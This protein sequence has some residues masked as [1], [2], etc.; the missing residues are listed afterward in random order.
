MNAR[1]LAIALVVLAAV[2]SAVL[3]GLAGLTSRPEDA[4]P[5]EH[6]EA[7]ARL[8]ARALDRDL[9]ATARGVELGA[10]LFDLPSLPAAETTGVLR[11]LYKQ[12][13]DLTAVVL[14]DGQDQAVVEPVF[15]R[16]EQVASR[17]DEAGH[18]PLSAEG[19]VRCLHNLPVQVAREKGFA[20]SDAYVDPHTNAVLVAGA[21]AVSAGPD[22]PAW[23]LGF[24]RNLRR[25]QKVVTAGLGGSEQTLWVVDGGGRLLAHPDGRRALAREPWAEHPLVAA[26][27]QGQRALQRTWQGADG[28]TMF[29]ALQRLD[30]ADWAVGLELAGPAASPGLP[31][32]WRWAAWFAAVLALAAVG[33]LG[34]RNLQRKLD[35][36]EAL[37]QEAERQQVELGRVQASLLESRKLNAI[38]DLG[39]GVAHEFNN[40]LGGILGLTQLLLRKKKDGDPDVEFLRRIETEA[41]RCKAI[42]DNLLRFSEQAGSNHRE[43]LRIERVMDKAVDLVLSKLDRQ[44]IRIVRDY[45]AELPRVFGS[46]GDLQRAYLNLLLNAETAMPEGGELRLS[47]ATDGDWIVTR[48]ADTGRGIPPENLERVFEPF[49]TTKDNWKGAGLGLWVVY[50]TV[51]EHG[52]SVA[53]E[54]QLGRGTVVTFRLPREGREQP[55]PGVQAA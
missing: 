4:R 18:L 30:T 20:M 15:L 17:G 38:G 42:T 45:A 28:R 33:L 22:Q 41:K 54:S 29:G 16:V 39:A 19:L 52:G 23:I 49:F 3:L 43:P 9:T 25:V 27:L 35:A 53:I 13:E 36:I 50:Q 44:R 34:A 1:S 46:E 2:L 11:I 24:E 51:Q 21:L 32:G 55:D 10:R 40:P 31:L 37:R 26:F 8:V 47:T 12:D 48:V 5:A 14:L 7:L 6:D